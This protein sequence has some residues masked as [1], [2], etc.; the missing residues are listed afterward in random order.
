MSRAKIE[1]TPSNL[2]ED[3]TTDNLFS[4]PQLD[5]GGV[6]G[7][8]YQFDIATNWLGFD[9]VDA[10]FAVDDDRTDT[11]SSQQAFNSSSLYPL[12]VNA[13]ERLKIST[14]F[15]PLRLEDM[16]VTSQQV[17]GENPAF[18]L[19]GLTQL[20][21]DPQFAGIDGSGFSVAVIDTGL[22]LN[23]PLIAPNYVA[24]YDFVDNDNNPNEPAEHGTHVAGIVAATD[25]TIGVAPDAGLI[26]LRVLNQQGEGSINEV[27]A[28][29]EWVFNNRQRYNITA[30][31]LS[32][33]VGFFANESEVSGNL[34]ADDIARLEAAGVTIVAAAGNSYSDFENTEERANI[35]FPAISSTIAVGAVWQDN[36]RASI[37]W[38][39]GSIDYSTGAD[40]I[41]A[42]SQ[43]LDAENFIFAPGAVITS[44][45]PNN[46]IGE[47]AGT[48]QASPHV[49]G[50]VA[51]LQE[52]SLQFDD[53]T[54]TPAE[55]NEILRTT[56]DRIFDGDD[57]DDNVTNT[58]TNY[59]RVN[60]YNAV[61]EIK[62]RA[63]ITV[64]VRNSND[65]ISQAERITL[66][67]S[68]RLEEIGRDEVE[69][70]GDKDVDFYLFNLDESGVLE[71]DVDAPSANPL[72]SVV[73]LFD[74][75]G[76]R[77]AV[78]DN[79]NS[80]DSNLRFLVDT[81]TDYYL[82]VTGA[83]NQN[84]DPLIAGSGTRG[85][86]GRY[87]LNARLSN[88]SG[89]TN[90]VDN[91]IDSPAVRTIDL[92]QTLFGNLGHDNGLAIGNQDVDLYRFTSTNSELVELET[93]ADEQFS[94]DTYLR[95]F[96][97]SGQEI[98]A[99]NDISSSN[100]ASSIQFEAIAGEEYYVGVNGNS[101]A[102]R[103]Y[104]PL[105]EANRAAGSL[106]N[107]NLRLSSSDDTGF[108]ASENPVYR[109]HHRGIGVNFFTTS[110]SERDFITDNLPQY[111]LQETS[112]ASA[113]VR[114]S[115]TGAKPVYRLF[116]T[117]TGAHL[118]TISETENDFIQ[119]NLTNYSSE[120]IAY[121]AY[122][123]QQSGTTALYR[124]YNTE[125]DT[126]F[127][128]SSL[129]E[130]NEIL[131]SDNNYRLEGNNGIAFYVESI[132]DV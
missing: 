91:T 83:D 61:A 74:G 31:N 107:Y 67:V 110:S 88:A 57:E 70:A 22:D 118:Y 105:T 35:G 99:N 11:N 36:S 124:L 58:E 5:S 104:S 7:S 42:F 29:L 69:Q 17:R 129:A 9:P 109:F 102:G 28:A 93:I 54:L 108:R 8:G 126:H 19:I 38:Q 98:A 2:I 77:L 30:V 62:R 116:N 3:S 37:A 14:P 121:Y 84:F 48:S 128:T 43:R 12:D 71:I 111:S 24:G 68:D 72:N 119:D 44:T 87:N 115:L 53:R 25:E 34:L 63:N 47:S 41:P 117:T 112:F 26:G 125:S 20:R 45:L 122:E 16:G 106:G 73:S 78:Q 6:F 86:T 103:Q 89:S 127:F 113:E 79:N 59:L 13:F 39:D 33:G 10:S 18:D 101:F 130:R 95:L 51:L 100:R 92:E 81:N 27:E 49:A 65:T 120:G 40:R 46:R 55:V 75:E 21:N 82:A 80:N 64:P 97:R 56:G 132:A 32:L 76:R 96:D 123:S 114:D 66:P 4:N 1:T 50:V 85:D 131:D 23:H 52:A 94:A 15:I 60:V 90:L